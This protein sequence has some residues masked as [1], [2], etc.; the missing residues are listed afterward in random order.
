MNEDK[1]IA[2]AISLLRLIASLLKLKGR[3]HDGEDDLPS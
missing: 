1:L 3:R 2:V